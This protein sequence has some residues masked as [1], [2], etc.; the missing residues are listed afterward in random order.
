MKDWKENRS[1]LA[2]MCGELAEI[3]QQLL[4]L[5]AMR[6]DVSI[7]IGK[8][9][10]EP[11]EDT[12]NYVEEKDV[13]ERARQVSLNLGLPESLAEEF[14]SL[15]IRNSLTRQEQQRVELQKSG[16]G[17]RVLVIGGAGR[18]GR[19]FAN[20][21]DSQGFVVEIADPIASGECLSHFSDWRETSLDHEIIVVACP[22]RATSEVLQG[23]LQRRPS[24]IILDVSSLK[25]PI[26]KG[27]CSLVDAGLQ[28]CSIH[29][30]FGPDTKLLSG[31]H[32][33]FIT[34]GSEGARQEIQ[35][36]FEP[37]MAE[38]VE[39]DLEDHDRLIAYVLG[40]SHALNIAFFTALV[41]S[42]EAAQQLARLSS[43]TF[44]SQLEVASK[45]AHD[46]P[47]LY[48]EIQSLNEYG[49]ESLS[50]LLYAVERLRS[51]VRTGDE[52]E[53]RMLME[54]GLNYLDSRDN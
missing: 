2:T 49:G 4:E 28:V 14:L 40:L 27:L 47:K 17:R 16:D 50:A 24:G 26:R 20:F 39:M 1:C 30:M 52:K 46:N 13:L 15:L 38:V 11:G 3:D 31:Q 35:R 36:L 6:L 53:F 22:I 48:F 37:T 7:E 10:Q 32:I 43:T 9:K 41:E 8:L 45:V 23:L 42:G 19:W 21:L 12:R 5:V 25:S 33:I 54:K 29:P 51:I 44:D 18:M 34:L